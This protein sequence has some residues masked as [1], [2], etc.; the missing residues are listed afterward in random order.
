LSGLA[1]ALRGTFIALIDMV[2]FFVL[3]TGA[4]LMTFLGNAETFVAGLPATLATGLAGAL[5]AGFFGVLEGIADPRVTKFIHKVGMRKTASPAR[6][7]DI[8]YYLRSDDRKLK[9]ASCLGEHL[10]CSPCGAVASSFCR[11]ISAVRKADTGGATV[12]LTMKRVDYTLL[13]IF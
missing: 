12:A 9:G 2:A 8:K 5:E 7:H 3:S 6:Y 13:P 4:A 1:V 10:V 11:V